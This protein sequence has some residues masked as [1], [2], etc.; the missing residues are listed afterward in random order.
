MSMNLN[1]FDVVRI[2][3]P[4]VGG[5]IPPQ[6]T[7]LK[8]LNFRGLQKSGPSQGRFFSSVLTFFCQTRLPSVACDNAPVTDDP[9]SAMKSHS[10]HRYGRPP[11]MAAE[12]RTP[13]TD[14]RFQDLLQ[15]AQAFFEEAEKDKETSRAEVIREILETM[16]RYG[17]G[18]DDLRDSG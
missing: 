4:R 8:S 1:I 12:S 13:L 2:E 9:Q 18:V 11:A 6:A 7:S 5:S 16:E 3:N 15:S 14:S 17:I 10:R